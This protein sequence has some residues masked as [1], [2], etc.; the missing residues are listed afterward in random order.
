MNGNKIHLLID[1]YKNPRPE[2]AE[3]L[4]FCFLENINSK[5]F[6]YIHI[7]AQSELP[8]KEI[9]DNV[10]IINISN[11]LTYQ[12]YIDYARNNIPK[13]DI[14]VLS[15]ADIFFDE[16]ILRV[17]EIDL[18]NKVLALTR[19]CPYHGHW[20][21]G[22]GQITPY[23]NHNRSQDVWVWENS[24]NI[25]SA[26]FNIGVLGCDNKIA[27]ELHKAGYQIWNPSFSIVCY[28]KHKE[29]NDELDHYSHSP[30]IWLSGPYLLPNVCLIENILDENYKF[31][32]TIE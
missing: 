16:S 15:N 18:S 6:D 21:D 2:R 3:E 7:F 31:Y 14:I 20:V 12:Y 4:D 5:E 11:R 30:K 29:R 32:I 10:K 26:N 23:H 1:Y 22:Q 28:H 24:L 17:K 13:G 27:F 19:F 8:I 9:P 25:T